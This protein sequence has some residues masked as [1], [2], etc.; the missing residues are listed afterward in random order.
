MPA[1]LMI[2]AVLA[3]ALDENWGKAMLIEMANEALEITAAV[4]TALPRFLVVTAL[5]FVL[6]G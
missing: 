1:Y 4:A 6:P 3:M 2:R 5:A